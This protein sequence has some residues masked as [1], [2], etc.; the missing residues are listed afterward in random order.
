LLLTG[1]PHFDCSGAPI[2]GNPAL[3]VSNTDKEHYLF[4]LLLFGVMMLSQLLHV[5]S[6]ETSEVACAW[7]LN[8]IITVL[9][10][11]LN[12]E[13]HQILIMFKVFAL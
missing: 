3:S 8:K 10:F 6:D 12:F 9:Y 13:N 7:P 11:E 5:V 1:A 2:T 4:Y